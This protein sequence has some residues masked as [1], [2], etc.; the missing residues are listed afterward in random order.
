MPAL[1][2]RISP[3]PE[4]ITTLKRR[5]SSI[6]LSRITSAGQS[7]PRTRLSSGPRNSIPRCVLSRPQPQ[8]EYIHLNDYPHERR[9][10]EEVERVRELIPVD[11]YYFSGENPDYNVGGVG[12][13]P[14]GWF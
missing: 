8:T 4:T 3:S 9:R 6:K 14:G 13:S 11:T 12:G 5:L 2:R 1:F 10:L 7:T